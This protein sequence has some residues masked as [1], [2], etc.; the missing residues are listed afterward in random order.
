MRDSRSAIRVATLQRWQ[1]A[2][3]NTGF[4]GLTRDYL[5]VMRGWSSWGRHYHTISRL[6]ACLKELDT[7]RQLAAPPG[8]VELSIWFHDVVYSTWRSD[9]EARS[10]AL[11]ATLMQ[12]TPE[13]RI[14]YETAARNTSWSAS[15]D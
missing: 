14:R 12:R 6:E 13:F 3:E 7:S 2:C 1:A 10:A 4:L 15:R 8:E 11:T 5:R 9:N